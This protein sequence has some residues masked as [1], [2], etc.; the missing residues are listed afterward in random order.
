M[1]L[2]LPESLV[3]GYKRSVSEGRLVTKTVFTLFSEGA[4][5]N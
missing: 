3:G 1:K 2:N 4:V 5:D